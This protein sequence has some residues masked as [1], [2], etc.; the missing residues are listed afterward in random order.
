M[1]WELRI[2]AKACACQQQRVASEA[3]P[4]APPDLA[5]AI[6]KRRREYSSNVERLLPPVELVG[7]REENE[8]GVPNPPD[9]AETIRNHRLKNTENR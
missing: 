4:D 7:S 8:H 9:L 6:L 3:P 5:E 1:P 2:G